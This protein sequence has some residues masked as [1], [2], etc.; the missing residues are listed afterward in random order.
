MNMSLKQK[1]I[2]NGT[3]RRKTAVAR[4]YMR[5]GNGKITVNNQEIDKYFPL[6]LQRGYLRAPIE[7]CNMKNKD[8]IITV[9]GGGI[10]GQAI[11]ARHGISRALVK[12]DAEQRPVL[13]EQGFLTRDPRKRERKKYGKA[14]ARKSFQFSKR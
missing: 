6:E 2:S 1:N 5:D 9:K 11:A 4:V 8:F 10:E 14:G 7:L 12:Y 13:K 3:G